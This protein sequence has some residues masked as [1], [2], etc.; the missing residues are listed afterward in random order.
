M[1]NH[2]KDLSKSLY[3]NEQGRLTAESLNKEIYITGMGC[4]SPAPEMLHRSMSYN[5]FTEGYFK[6]EGVIFCVNVGLIFKV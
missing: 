6:T 3:V 4:N 5:G 2:N 1:D